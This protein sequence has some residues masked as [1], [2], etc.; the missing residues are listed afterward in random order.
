[1]L[2]RW[3]YTQNYSWLLSISWV[4]EMVE[5]GKFQPFIS[6]LHYLHQENSRCKRT[7]KKGHPPVQA[8]KENGIKNLH[9]LPECVPILS[10][11]GIYLRCRQSKL[12]ICV[13]HS[14]PV[15][16]ARHRWCWEDVLLHPEC[17]A[18]SSC[19][20]LVALKESCLSKSEY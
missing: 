11:A 12:I 1:M 5:T 3:H 7:R 17:A 2:W 13:W 14:Q 8:G 4:L 20:S 15:L 19:T 16:T 10:S 6:P 9:C 18:F